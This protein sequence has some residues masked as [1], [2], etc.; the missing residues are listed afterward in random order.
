M[1]EHNDK[2]FLKLFIKENW[3]R[4]TMLLTVGLVF[5]IITIN[6]TS[7]TIIDYYNTEAKERINNVQKEY[8]IDIPMLC[9]VTNCDVVVDKRYEENPLVFNFTKKTNVSVFPKP[10]EKPK[11][12]LEDIFKQNTIK[13]PSTN[14]EVIK[15]MDILDDLKKDLFIRVISIFLVFAILSMLVIIQFERIV[16]RREKYKELHNMEYNI[17]KDLTESVHHELAGPL[18]VIEGNLDMFF[19]SFGKELNETQE[20][21]IYQIETA[22]DSIKAVLKIMSNCKHIKYSNGA[23]SIN[24]IIDSAISARTLSSLNSVLINYKHKESLNDIAVKGK[25]SNGEIYNAI[26]TLIINATEADAT[27]IDIDTDINDRYIDI[28][29]K[30]N[31]SGVRDKNGKIDPNQNIFRYGYSTKDKDDH[32]DVEHGLVYNM[33]YSIFG[34]KHRTRST[35]GAG[36]AIN[37]NIL[38]AHGGDLLLKSTSEKGSVFQLRI[39]IKPRRKCMVEENVIK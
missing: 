39:P 24:K 19:K 35:R 37:K 10:I 27:K 4:F 13:V 17:Q 22:I 1:T 18:A 36:L 8:G 38:K 29:V 3:P 14:I 16:G 15:S 20:N 28:V 2:N 34:G 5:A 31:G 11:N 33:I 30:D 7:S 25:L 21:Y 32:P 23:I 6:I 12:L 26:N 9:L